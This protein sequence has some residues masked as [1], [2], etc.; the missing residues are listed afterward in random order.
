MSSF[1]SV[2]YFF[3]SPVA[4]ESCYIATSFAFKAASLKLAGVC[5]GFFKQKSYNL[6]YDFF[7]T[8]GIR[9]RSDDWELEKTTAFL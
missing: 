1:G 6:L 5:E 9:E 4:S 2:A 8:R 7:F 3:I